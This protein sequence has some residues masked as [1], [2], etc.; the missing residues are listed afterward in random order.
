L[1]KAAGVPLGAP[2]PSKK[3]V[4][5]VP[6]TS[7]YRP[8]PLDKFVSSRGGMSRPPWRQLRPAVQQAVSIDQDP[9]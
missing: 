1:D 9:N 4:I 3:M 5:G 7:W 6:M 8:E 2:A